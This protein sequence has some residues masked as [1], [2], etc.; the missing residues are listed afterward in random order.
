MKVIPVAA[1]SLGVR[2]MATYI[3]CGRSRI[4]IDPGAALGPSRFGLPPA[5]AE[6]EAL[7]RSND[8]IAAYATRAHLVFVSHYH[9]DHF[10]YDPGLYD[11][12]TVWAKD[13]RRMVNRT[14]GRRG[15]EL[16]KAIKERCRLEAAEGKCSELPDAILSASPPLA[17]GAEGSGLGYVVALTVTDRDDGFRFVFAA[18]VQGPVSP[19]VTAYL[20]R[21]RPNLLYLSGPP[22]YLERQ[23]GSDAIEQGIANLLRVIEATRCRVILDHHALR[24]PRYKERLA[25]LWETERVVTAAGHLD[26]ADTC[27]E[28]SRNLLWAEQ[29]KPGALAGRSLKPPAGSSMIKPRARI[30]R[31]RGGNPG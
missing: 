25:R 3:E 1:E 19:V 7:K 6:W 29:R 28:A 23:L 10:R 31:A 30:P 9:G 12:R 2:S 15:A 17:H 21:E 18:D 24:D 13:P 20:I 14:Q 22:T 26:L 11:G 4:L 16:W 27:L 8:R 5:D